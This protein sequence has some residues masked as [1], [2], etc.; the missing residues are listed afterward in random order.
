[1]SLAD[2]PERLASWIGRTVRE[3]F[4]FVVG[5][6]LVIWLAWMFGLVSLPNV[7]LP[8]WT[9]VLGTFGA[10]A[11]AGGYFAASIRYDE[12]EPDWNYVV[13]VNIDDPRTPRISRATDAVIQDFRMVKG[14]LGSPQG[15][16]SI[17]YCRWWNRDPENPIGHAS[18]SELPSDT[19][20]LGVKPSAIEDEVSALRDTYEETHGKFQWVLDHLYMVIRRLDF[21]RTRSQNEVLEEHVAPSMDDRGVAEV[22][23]EVIPD[24]LQPE[25]LDRPDHLEAGA[26]SEAVDELGEDVDP[27]ATGGASESAATDGGEPTDE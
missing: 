17:F 11:A 22:V 10:I 15:S 20:L 7:T 9:R 26:G 2:T 6:V 5:S 4:K 3:N 1:M 27:T 25:N 8:L 21:R 24:E 16:D 13:E 23:D 12:P 19:D 18:W 14:A